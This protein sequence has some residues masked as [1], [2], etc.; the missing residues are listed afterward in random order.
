MPPTPT[1]GFALPIVGRRV[2][3]AQ[4]TPATTCTLPAVGRRPRVAYPPPNASAA[5]LP[6]RR[7]SHDLSLTPT[8][9]TRLRALCECCLSWTGR[10]AAD[11]VFS[12]A[13]HK[14]DEAILWTYAVFGLRCREVDHRHALAYADQAPP[15]SAQHQPAAA[16]AAGW[17]RSCRAVDFA[18]YP[19]RAATTSLGRPGG[20]RPSSG[21]ECAECG[22]SR[23]GSVCQARCNG[24]RRPFPRPRAR[25]LCGGTS[26]SGR[27][28]GDCRGSDSR[29]RRQAAAGRSTEGVRAAVG[30]P[31][32]L[33]RSHGGASS[34][35]ACWGRP[36]LRAG[37][38]HEAQR[39]AWSV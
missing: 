30:C 8:A 39:Q 28:S 15:S 22:R 21:S 4:G 38:L 17:A 6:V 13:N 25:R 9:A 27:A 26:G 37:R 31:L 35:R 36:Q 3:K 23:W 1:A 10:Y 34:I 11:C 20:C 24:R 12:R 16:P 7:R 29:R 32:P 5:P 19:C 14:P 18:Y 33:L 2:A